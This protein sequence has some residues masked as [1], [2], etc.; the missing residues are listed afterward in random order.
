MYVHLTSQLIVAD[1]D[2]YP[3]YS[4]GIEV[5]DANAARVDIVISDSTIASDFLDVT[6]QV[7]NDLQNWEDQFASTNTLAA[8]GFYTFQDS[9]FSTD[10]IAARYLRLKFE[11]GASAT[12]K[13]LI[14]AAVNLTHV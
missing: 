10:K 4:R 14:R 2:S 1:A 7:S 11:L 13:A 12:G 9:D 6:V 8:N 5:G 3:C